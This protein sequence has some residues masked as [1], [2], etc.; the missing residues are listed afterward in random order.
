MSPGNQDK[1]KNLKQK[2]T[3]GLVVV[4]LG[5]VAWQ[6]MGMFG[7]G[8]SSPAPSAPTNAPN[9]T[10]SANPQQ[11]AGNGAPAPA[12]Q[13][14]Q[15]ATV[16]TSSGDNTPKQA[17]VLANAELLQLQQETQA[18]YI[19]ALNELDMLKVQKSIAETKQAITTSTLATATAEKNITDLLTTQV[20]QMPSNNSLSNQYSPFASSGGT[21]DAASPTSSAPS[22]NGAPAAPVV[23]KISAP[24]TQYFLQSVAYKSE[25]WSAVL[26]NGKNVFIVEIGD[27]LP[28]DG[29]VV[30]GIDKN[31]VTLLKDKA[32]RHIQ[33]SPVSE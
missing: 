1:G 21:G 10:M 11:P 25:K 27:T 29:S 5:F 26:M 12:P 8:G 7:G 18:K 33:M 22:S 17:P 4:V 14:S 19:A 2:I 30:T 6:A 31:A 28:P 24:E 16:T 15:A 20:S 23:I 32:S 3:I 13:V 9:K